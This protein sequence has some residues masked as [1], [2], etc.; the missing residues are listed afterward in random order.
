MANQVL[1]SEQQHHMLVTGKEDNLIDDD[2]SYKMM[3]MMS[4]MNESTTAASNAINQYQQ[5]NSDLIITDHSISEQKQHQHAALNTNQNIQRSFNGTLQNSSASSLNTSLS[6]N[7]LNCTPP[8]QPLM[9][10]NSN[11]EQISACASCPSFESHYWRNICRNCK[12]SKDE[13]QPHQ[14]KSNDSS[15]Q[16]NSQTNL[17]ISSSSS[18]NSNTSSLMLPLGATSATL[19]NQVKTNSPARAMIVHSNAHGQAQQ[20]NASA[21]SLIARQTT[22][23][24]D[25]SGCAL[26]E[27]TWVPP[28]LKPDQVHQYFS[29]ISDDKIPYV[30]SFGEKYRIKQLLNQLP[31]HD[32]EARY[33][34]PLSNEELDQLKLFSQQ[35]K[36]ESLGRA[37]A[38][39]IPLTNIG[40]ID[41]R[42]CEKPVENGSIGIFA[43]RAGPQ[44]CWHP[45]CFL[46]NTCDELL[47]DLIY[48]YNLNDSK[49]Y[50]GRH[51]AELYKPRCPACDEIIFSD[52]CTEAEGRSWHMTHFACFDCNELLG[53]QRYFMKSSKPYCCKCF[54]KVHIEFCATCG[55]SIGVEQGQITYEDQ[56]WHATDEC[57]SCA[58]CSK[59]LRGG[60]MFIPKHGVIYCSNACLKYKSTNPAGNNRSIQNASQTTATSI[61]NNYLNA[62]QIKLNLM[63][64]QQKNQSPLCSPGQQLNPSMPSQQS[65]LLISNQKS[66]LS[67]NQVPGNTSN[68]CRPTLPS[69]NVPQNLPQ[70][71]NYVNTD[72]NSGIDQQLASALT[73]QCRSRKPVTYP[74]ASDYEVNDQPIGQL[75]SPNNNNCT[76][77]HKMNNPQIMKVQNYYNQEENN[78][79]D[80]LDNVECITLNQHKLVRSRHSMSDLNEQL[81]QRPA[82]GQ[83]QQKLRSS[84]KNPKGN[85]IYEE[86][87]GSQ[88][89]LDQFGQQQNKTSLK[90]AKPQSI[91]KRYDSSEKMNPISRPISCEMQSSYNFQANGT[92]PRHHQHQQPRKLNSNYL[93]ANDDEAENNTRLN[94]L[95]S[96]SAACIGNNGVQPRKR[97]QFANIPP[98]NTCSSV[99]DLSSNTR[100]NR[101]TVEP[102]FSRP[103]TS[104][105]RSGRHSHHEDMYQMNRRH[106][107]RSHHGSSHR[108]SSSTSNFNSSTLSSKSHNRYSSRGYNNHR[109]HRQLS[110]RSLNFPSGNDYTDN[111]YEEYN[112]A[113]EFDDDRTCST[114][115][116]SSS[117]TTSSTDSESDFDDGFGC[118]PLDDYPRSYRNNN[119]QAMSLQRNMN[120]NPSNPDTFHRK[121]NSGLKISYVDSLPLAR[122]NPAPQEH[123]KSKKSVG[124]SNKKKSIS[125]FKKDNCTV[126]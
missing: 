85:P 84:L 87:Y 116:Y 1:I 112:S 111:D 89:D 18:L 98:L 50:C 114:C 15:A 75:Q 56:H 41:C 97:V 65:P 28:G 29:S 13:H 62:P 93:G 3:L 103:R 43:A 9:L 33:C 79:F 34:N 14:F 16:I 48:F 72:T 20:A 94:Q 40:Q 82:Q 69:S 70:F 88:N 12:C 58:T 53:G 122:T 21:N 125:K 36:R 100:N 105:D 109:S 95:S 8:P 6:R 107:H 32:N 74:F 55:K 76:Q 123:K 52:E 115:S 27:Y 108:R 17:I 10:S 35:R 121:Y 25:D 71:N 64:Q 118:D 68:N 61:V 78:S 124:S 37:V 120:R 126:S 90:Q 80:D 77:K 86:N 119:N 57:F 42:H 2:L 91:L 38:R 102:Q 83:Q 30:N 11:S 92:F 39:Q 45:G 51:H 117:N 24:D 19:Q 59:S 26:E 7:T 46:C 5:A 47:V 106:G 81:Q 63:Q 22:S 4:K 31:P 113:C 101:Y 54:E 23:D 66:N 49:V 104:R 96:S 73:N 99:G 67:P 44:A 110:N 60:L